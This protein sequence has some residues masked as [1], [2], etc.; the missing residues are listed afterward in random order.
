[1]RSFPGLCASCLFLLT[2]LLPLTP[3]FS[4]NYYISPTGSDLNAGTSP[5]SAWQTLSRA[6]LGTFGPGDSILLQGGQ[7]FTGPLLLPNL[8]TGT[9]ANP[10]YIGT[11]GTGRATI[12]AGTGK[13]VEIKNVSNLT[14]AN[15]IVTGSGRAT[16]PNIGV[17]I[18]HDLVPNIVLP[19]LTIRNVEVS[20][21]NKEGIKV[22]ATEWRSGFSNV[23]I[24]DVLS[25]DNG[26][27]GI[28]VTGE[29]ESSTAPGY[30]HFNVTIRDCKAYNNPGEI[31]KTD[32]HTGNG[33]IVS[34]TE[35][36]LVE[37][38]EAYGNGAE[39]F[40]SGGGPVGIWFW[41]VKDGII[42]H[43]ESYNNRTGST[44]D[45]G[46]FDLDGGCVN[47]VMQYNYSHGND[48]AGF[49][50]AHFESSRSTLNNTIRFNISENDARKTGF[51][52]IHFWRAGSATRPMNGIRVYHNTVFLSPAPQGTPAAIETASGNFNN[53]Q[54]VNN[55]FITTGGAR[56]VDLAT[57]SNHPQFIE[58]GYFSSGGT[59]AIRDA[60]TVYNS[61]N[62]WRAARSKEIYNS[63]NTG[64]QGDPLLT[65]P[66]TAG[67]IGNP[68]L[69]PTMANYRLQAGS[70][71][72]N[73][74]I[75]IVSAFS[76]PIGSRDFFAS[77]IGA[78]GISDIGSHYGSGGP[79][80]V[81]EVNLS[82]LRYA[83]GQVGLF[84]EGN[85]PEGTQQLDIER[86]LTRQGLFETLARMPLTSTQ[87]MDLQAPAEKCL[88][89]L[90]F[91]DIDGLVHYSNL[92][93][94]STIGD[95]LRL[96]LYPNPAQSHFFV[97]GVPAAEQ[98]EWQLLDPTG[99]VIIS[100]V[101]KQPFDNQRID[102]PNSLP[103]GVYLF[104]VTGENE[105]AHGYLTIA[106]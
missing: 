97:Q 35:G 24:R 13:G 4:A 9:V 46:G 90:A 70:P 5:A 28:H 84:W 66:G 11:Y 10:V 7:T 72:L 79:F 51:G 36:A 77:P 19:N 44:A 6:N 59:F 93:E 29:F 12:N 67:T 8:S 22:Y 89:R 106:P 3:A 15:L 49:L 96:F 41:D 40:Y 86:S 82:A 75:N 47:S 2:S 1:M 16:N 26:D 78:G 94:V 42:Q 100:G 33:I 105:Q 71:A 99:R 62:A 38:C 34:N 56:L 52:A 92:A 103:P 85:A 63:A 76:V 83:D 27:V 55:L 48:G 50:I 102:L 104:H 54:V 45:G 74:G 88:Y 37:Y 80:P 65:S 87:Y 60:G 57:T 30:C 23:L 64:F 53:L 25:H 17:Y 68:Y 61:L 98:A 20:G 101:L 95:R 81:A 18:W 69:L 31:G 91:T 43:C 73:S 21:F 32:K 58:N 39:S 14:V